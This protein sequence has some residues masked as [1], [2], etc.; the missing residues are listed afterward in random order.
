M[1]TKPD[2]SDTLAA[3]KMHLGKTESDLKYDID[4][5]GLVDLTDVMGLQKAYL[6][7]DP[8]FAFAEDSYF[9]SPSTKTAADYAA[10]KQAE[11][12]RIAAEQ[13]ETERRQGLITDARD[14]ANKYHGFYGGTATEGLEDLVAANPN[15]TAG[16]L[17]S[18]STKNTWAKQVPV[19]SRTMDAMEKGTA[20]LEEISLG[21]DEFGNDMRQLVIGNPKDP[22]SYLNL[23]ETS[24]PGIYQFST[25]NPTAAGMLHGF[26]QADPS[27][28]TYTPIQDYT[29]QVRYTPGQSGGFLGNMI[30]DFADLYKSMGPIGGII[31]NAIAPGLGSALSAIA[32]IDEGNT[33]SGVLNALGAAGAYGNAA[34]Q[35]GDTSGLG[36]TLAQN[37]PEIKTATNALQLANAV[38]SGNIGGALNAAGNLAGVSATPEVKTAVQAVGLVQALDSGNTAQALLLAGQLT[39]NPDVK[40]AGDAVK[41]VNA[42][43]SGNP[44]AAQ[45]AA[46]NIA[47]TTG[48]DEVA[49]TVDQK[50]IDAVLDAPASKTTS[51]AGSILNSDEVVAG[52]QQLVDAITNPQT[53]V[54]Y[55][56]TQVADVGR[57]GD[58]GSGVYFDSSIGAWRVADEPTADDLDTLGVGLTDTQTSDSTQGVTGADSLEGGSLGT[59]SDLADTVDGGAGGLTEQ[60][61]LDIVSGG[62]GDATLTGGDGT[63]VIADDGTTEDIQKVIDDSQ[64]ADDGTTADIQKVI[65]DSQVADDGTTADIQ[66]VIDDTKTDTPDTTDTTK[67]T[68]TTTPA[69][70]ATPPPNQPAVTTQQPALQQESASGLDLLGLLA[71]MGGGGQQA[72][73]AQPAGADLSGMVDIEDLLANPLQA[74]PRKL[75]RQS[76][77]AEGGSIDDLLELLNKRS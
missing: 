63:D 35:A 73:P 10:E 60:E 16:Q 21:T 44:L 18:L 31:G 23:R 8:G 43:N 27:K 69:K 2:L 22:N 24:Q 70:P 48:A 34:L 28:G 72:Q 17:A 3:L 13:K 64:V 62:I 76:K 61:L 67:T 12:E 30:G 71:L 5:N 75:A 49:S 41:L 4:G 52:T 66:K 46:L 6:G 9:Q 57:A 32:A 65:D 38:E 33:T 54:S 51:D 40:V 50:T 25:F 45:N 59:A 42:L 11:Q 15:L 39:D 20:K 74:D 14:Y 36:G 55:P 7:K 29:K 68:T 26:I 1:A 77:M 56:G 58:P 47:K 53:T 19:F 37:L